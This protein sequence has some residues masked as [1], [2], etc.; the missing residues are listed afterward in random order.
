MFVYIALI[1]V[2]NLLL[3]AYLAQVFDLSQI[4]PFRRRS[5]PAAETLGHRA[6][7]ETGAIS[8]AMVDEHSA[9]AAE[10]ASDDFNGISS[11]SDRETRIQKKALP[12]TVKT[13][14]DFAQQL[15]DLKSRTRYCRPAQ[16]MKLARQAAEQL[17]ACA[18]VW[19]AQFEK[20][21][22]GDELD[23]AT[24]DLVAGAEMGAIEMFAAQIETTIANIGAL[25]FTG[26][27]DD[28][29]NLLE[30]ELELLD[31]QQRSVAGGKKQLVPA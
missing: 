20:C 28:V 22:L 10:T 21:L 13:W 26:S 27:A 30:K 19:Y 14:D 16:D 18:I 1:A 23:E 17:K 2:V 24:R 12:K 5:V 8:R 25:D 7:S 3:G 29:L 9:Q 6:A 4:F 15:R 31:S 11:P